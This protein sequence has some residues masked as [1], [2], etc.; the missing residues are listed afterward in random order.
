M[1]FEM[2]ENKVLSMFVVLL[3]ISTVSVGLASAQT[4]HRD[5]D[6]AEE[7]VE[8]L[9][10]SL[11]RTIRILETSFNHSINVD[12]DV[13]IN[14]AD[15][16]YNYSFQDLGEAL[17]Y[18]K[19]ALDTVG[20]SE[21]ILKDIEG[22]VSSYTYLEALYKPYSRSSHN[23]TTFTEAHIDFI[24]NLEKAV[25]VY[26]EWKQN[27]RDLEY[28]RQ[29]LESLNRASYD[30]NT[31]RYSIENTASYIES[32]DDERLENEG[33]LDNILDI[34]EILD[35]YNEFIEDILWLY[36]TIPSHIDLVLPNRGHPGEEITIYGIYVESG[37]YLDDV[38][39]SLSVENV[40]VDST[41]TDE[42]GYYHFDY[43]IPWDTELGTLNVSVSS[44]GLN[45]S[46]ELEVVKYH[47]EINL[48]LDR[49]EYYQQEVLLEGEFKTPARV[50]LTEISLDATFNRSVDLSSDGSFELDYSSG[51]FSFG[52]NS[53]VVNY[54][55][56][57]TIQESRSTVHF[58]I[59]IP[60]ALTLESEKNGDVG[61]IEELPISG[62]L[63]NSSS[64]EG[65]EGMDIDIKINGRQ[66]TSIETL[67]DGSYSE[68][69][70]VDDVAPDDGLYRLESV[71]TGTIRYRSSESEPIFIYRRGDAI[72]IG[73]DPDEAR[74]GVDDNDD[75][76]HGF[77]P[78][79][80]PG[81]E[82]GFII[83]VAV[84]ISLMFFYFI[85]YK[86]KPIEEEV[87]DG[88][89][90][91]RTPLPV[92]QVQSGNDLS[93]GSKDDIPRIYREFVEMLKDKG[94]IT[95]RKG[96]THRDIEKEISH[97]TSSDE[98][99]TVTSVFEKAFFSSKDITKNEIER[100][101]ECLRTLNRVIG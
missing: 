78:W 69:L 81:L 24:T 61:E 64:D 22:E 49:D 9:Y 30:L 63:L 56:N 86:N 36:S 44:N 45:R 14:D 97:K 34:R 89:T 12:L 48:S 95:F 4:S 28:L 65:L 57:E 29:G 32:F 23:I 82:I 39:V 6:E 76:K 99:S 19:E 88:K 31:L 96:T 46:T 33:L 98:I 15:V 27:N 58:V 51:L 17:N 100:F 92:F 55:G 68:V 62:D 59:N 71:F 20:Y 85:F 3:L 42:N 101:N 50:P 93:A 26:E 40:S 13:E 35:E 72:G 73:E 2:V 60:T 67:D 80:T 37:A 41:V 77:I 91:E 90:E 47:S 8:A 25:Q 79:V 11:S 16:Y 52:T 10:V 66:L 7:D 87:H 43:K 75:E 38:E 94:D 21:D 5:F 54:M 74:D 1:V 84:L 83:V 70:L 53:L 18:S